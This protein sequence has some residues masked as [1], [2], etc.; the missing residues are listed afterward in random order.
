MFGTIALKNK[1]KELELDKRRIEQ[2]LSHERNVMKQEMEL[3]E[4]RLKES[5]EKERRVFEQEKELQVTRNE[6]EIHNLKAQLILK[7]EQEVEQM[8]LS[9]TKEVNELNIEAQKEIVEEKE[10]LNK[11]FYTDMTDELTRLNKDGNH[12]TDF[13]KT[14]T[15]EMLKTQDVKRID[16]SHA[17]A[18]DITVNKVD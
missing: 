3:R 7:H 17:P 18:S 1:I 15:L 4:E 11:K 5:L 13:M 6:E 14:M 16:S 9:H 8:K 12:M 2:E 10:K